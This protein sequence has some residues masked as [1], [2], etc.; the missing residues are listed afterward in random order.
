MKKVLYVLALVIFILSACGT[1]AT[2]APVPTNTRV[3]LPTETSIPTATFEPSPM[4]KPIG[5]GTI[6]IGVSNTIF[7]RSDPSDKIFNWFSS[8]SD[9]SNFIALKEYENIY[10]VS[11]DGKYLLASTNGLLVLAR[12]DQSNVSILPTESETY[13][14]YTYEFR[15]NMMVT[16]IPS[17][18]WLPNGKLAFLASE[19]RYNEKSS[20]YIVNLD[21][22]KLMKLQ[23]PA[24]LINDVTNFLF[25]SADGNKIYW[26]TGTKCIDHGTCNE[27][28]F[29]TT[30]DDSEQTQI[31]KNIQ[32][33]GKKIYPSPSKQ[34]IAYAS[35]GDCYLATIDGKT[36][37]KIELNGNSFCGR[38]SPWS[39]VEDKLLVRNMQDEKYRMDFEIRSVPENNT[40]K[41]VNYNNIKC[42]SSDWTPDGKSIFFSVCIEDAKMIGQR[43]V[44]L[45][46]DTIIEYPDFGYCH[47]LF[48]PDSKW[49]LFY[50]C[51]NSAS[52][53]VYSA[54]RLNLETKESFPVF[55]EFI[56]PDA[57]MSKSGW[58]MFWTP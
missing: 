53:L 24:G 5:E 45:S 51:L 38:G 8:A 18:L 30:I 47:Y 10:S 32:D 31:W 12:T 42:F 50:R 43:L 17:V 39:P 11:P 58:Y 41:A 23:K 52:A 46:D 40:I 57:N 15:N 9:G 6:F 55:E 21:D 26:V 27:K 28:Y 22:N 20:I 48:S 3:S 44:N 2:T 35:H 7:P 49:A 4:P 1:P 34:Y 29:S 37:N 36:L 14:A 54:Q 25:A 56:S 13:L 33:A 19:K 16:Y